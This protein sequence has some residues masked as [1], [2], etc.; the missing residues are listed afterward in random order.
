MCILR[1]AVVLAAVLLDSAARADT[2]EVSRSDST[3]PEIAV[4]AKVTTGTVAVSD[5]QGIAYNTAWQS[6]LAEADARIRISVRRADGTGNVTILLDQAGP[7]AGT[8]PW[9]VAGL[10]DGRYSLTY[11]LLDGEGAAVQTS[12]S[13]LTVEDAVSR[14]DATSTEVVVNAKVTTGTVAV[15]DAQ[16]IAYNTAWQSLLAEADARIRISVRRADGTGN[17]MILLDQA[18]PCAGTVPWS[19]V[20]LSGGSYSLTY[21]VLDGS[22]AV[23]QTSASTLTVVDRTSCSTADSRGTDMDASVGTGT[24]IR[25]PERLTYSTAWQSG[26]AEEGLRSRMSLWRQNG[27]GA[28]NVLQELAG[29]CSGIYHWNSAG[30]E[31]GR[32]TVT[33]EIVDASGVLLDGHT[34]QFLVYDPNTIVHGGTLGTNETWSA[35]NIHLVRSKVIVPSGVTLTIE[36]GTIVKFESGAG[37]EVLTGGTLIARGV[38]FTHAADDTLGGDTNLDGSGSKP[39][40]DAYTISGT[41]TL[42]MDS[43]TELRYT[44][45]KTAGTISGA[46]VW[47]PGRTYSVTGD[48]TVA[49]GGT[50]TLSPGAIV[51]FAA[52][53]SLIINSNGTLRALGTRAQPIIFTSHKDDTVGGDTNG[54]G[55]STLPNLGDWGMVKLNGGTGDFA[56]CT[57]LYGGGVN[58]NQYGARANVFFWSSGRGTFK[59]CTFTRSPMDGCFAQNATFENCLFLDS[60]RGLCAHSGNVTAIN[61]VFAY[62]RVGVFNHGSTLTVKNSISAFNT[63]SGASR[64]NGSQVIQSCCFWNPEAPSGNLNGVTAGRSIVGDPLFVDPENGNFALKTGS[65]CIDAADTTVAPAVDYLGT[66]RINTSYV[67]PTGIPDAQGVYADI[68]ISEFVSVDAPSDV[69]LSAESVSGTAHANVGEN[70]TVTWRVCNIG[71][72]PASGTRVDAIVLSAADPALGVQRIVLGD[73]VV[74]DTLQPG[75]ARDY[76]ASFRLPSVQGG[77]WAYTVTAN[78]NRGVFEGSLTANNSK[79]SNARL[80]IA[81]LSLG[82]GSSTPTLAAGETGVWKM[83]GN[84]WR[85]GAVITLSSRDL[86]AFVGLGYAPSADHYDYQVIT[87]GEGQYA[88]VI[89]SRA[90]QTE[91]FLSLHNTGDASVTP[92]INVQP[93]PF[94]LWSIGTQSVPNTGKF[95]VALRGTRLDEV[96]SARI[97]L[98]A[99]TYNA[100]W[101]EHLSATEVAIHLDLLNIPA[102]AY[103]V[104]V[105]D[106]QGHTSEL[107]GALTVIAGA[108]YDQKNFYAR[109]EMPAQTRAGRPATAYFIYGNNGNTDLPA[110]H[111]TLLPGQ[112]IGGTWSG[113]RIPI[114]HAAASALPAKELSGSGISKVTAMASASSASGGGGWAGAGIPVTDVTKLEPDDKL[115]IR[116]SS[117]EE[118]QNGGIEIFATSATYPAS[119]LKAGEERRIP[120]F[121]METQSLRSVLYLSWKAAFEPNSGNYPWVAN[122]ANMRPAWAN[123]ETWSYILANLKASVGD[124]WDDYHVKLRDNLDY[125]A[126]MGF[127]TAR[128]GA[129]WQIEVNSAI[130]PNGQPAV[131]ASDTDLGVAVRGGAI[132][133]KRIYGSSLRHRFTRGIFGYGWTHGYDYAVEL[134]ASQKRLYVYSASLG[135][136]TYTYEKTADSIPQWKPTDTGNKVQLAETA[137]AYVLTDRQSNVIRLDKETGDIVS[138]SDNAGNATSFE[139]ADTNKLT[140]VRHTDGRHLLFTYSGD[141][142]SEVTDDQGASVSYTYNNGSLTSVRDNVTSNIT[143]YAYSSESGIRRR[144]LT[145]VRYPDNTT[146]D[147]LYDTM[148]RVASVSRNGNRETV[149]INYESSAIASTVD[150]AGALTRTWY[151]PGGQPLAVQDALGGVIRYTYDVDRGLLTS[152]T[153]PNGTVTRIDYDADNNPSRTVSP[154]GVATGFASDAMGLLASFTDAR[155][156]TTHYNR[157][158]KGNTLAIVYPDA[159]QRAFTYDAKNQLVTATNRR[160]QQVA[161]VR[162]EFGRVTQRTYPDGRTFAYTYN[163]KNR[164]LTASDTLTGTITFT[165]DAADRLHSVVYPDGKGFTYTYDAAGRL[166]KRVSEDGFALNYAYG[167]DGNLAAVSDKDGKEYVRYTFDDLT[168]RIASAAYGNGT[169]TEYAFDIAGRTTGI[170]HKGA[171]GQPLAF[172]NYAYDAN[173]D[174]AAMT[175][176]SGVTAYAYDAEHQLVQAAYPGGT[177]NAFAYDTVGNR[178]TA[179]GVPYTVNALNQYTQVGDTACQYDA[180]GNLTRKG[181]MTFEYDAENRLVSRIRAD[182]TVWSSAYNALGQRMQVVDGGVTNRFVF[183]AVGNLA[184]ECDGDGTL[185]R[186]YI[187]AGRLVAD[188]EAAGT[189]RYYHA[190]LQGSTRA[191]TSEAGA[192][193]GTADYSAFGAITASTGESSRFG[194]VGAY[195]VINDG[196]DVLFMR[197]RY[198]E[199][200]VGRFLHIDPIGLRSGDVNWY[201][202]C[203]NNGISLTDPKGLI[204]DPCDKIKDPLFKFLDGEDEESEIDEE[205]FDETFDSRRKFENNMRVFQLSTATLAGTVL[206]Y[207]VISRVGPA[208]IAALFPPSAPIMV[209][210]AIRP[211]P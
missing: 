120:I 23:V 83:D 86:A 144:A 175:N 88:V 25:I 62:N 14:S 187:R 206:A 1:T 141:L 121:Y 183:D 69:D 78:S 92:T 193:I 203:K 179:D 44:T 112:L 209:P 131:L 108:L 60:D 52:G 56:Y 188:E 50:L 158:A 74:S 192:V 211:T 51:K 197:H 72:K 174:I 89:P 107:S 185:T 8:V 33:H 96:S 65:P 135:T 115:Y 118:W 87:L 15:S 119:M 180:D 20:G 97:A 5:A 147:Y 142:V 38:R 138:V 7:C 57:F 117:N 136:L 12:A 40:P 76:S 126:S 90:S 172:F 106:G 169:R 58:G 184:A 19:V 113:G 29:P 148:G 129:A 6:L 37:I 4:N 167:A 145:Q 194:Y 101:V 116:L 104:R 155:G 75:E 186:R 140:A 143:A 28:T 163:A 48:I 149:A 198:Y 139:Y 85:S 199:C 123:D 162:D 109:F 208:A 202:Y 16:G 70:V 133:V 36:P 34:A 161:L 207:E 26:V 159:S 153:L 122:A 13:T 32:Y 10:S 130:A 41:G 77:T 157:D 171:D 178:V 160:K 196:D 191:L 127:V 103:T 53:K 201:R 47:L 128:A 82:L 152:M 166:S 55:V 195:G 67:V 134:Q 9:S 168:G 182:G 165:Y 154:K 100:S 21:E 205:D 79:T 176:A 3:S 11:E 45:Q 98:G 61:C 93:L 31:P 124:T 64:D 189:R 204:E 114:A 94:K 164:L 181:E 42:T 210:I 111:V 24:L 125:L 190:D 43:T 35:G 71:T 68:G 151:G 81:S 99:A 22:G 95:V 170:T 102:G 177:T 46:K 17:A 2:N 18:G 54:D 173:Y 30:V 63:G 156:K 84:L 49:S 59:G 27:G 105:D 146:L 73:K 66:P 39:A 132:G 200:L 110:P 91:L 150:A 80:S 137:D